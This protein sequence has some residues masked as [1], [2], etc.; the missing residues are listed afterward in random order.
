MYS[1]QISRQ[2]NYGSFWKHAHQ[3]AWEGIYLNMEMLGEGGRWERR[4]TASLGI[5]CLFEYL[6]KVTAVFQKRVFILL[7]EDGGHVAVSFLSK[8]NGHLVRGKQ[9]V[10]T[11]S[12]ASSPA[13]TIQQTA[14]SSKIGLSKCDILAFKYLEVCNEDGRKSLEYVSP[15]LSSSSSSSVRK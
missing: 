14:A 4:V 8:W 13:V 7:R 3:C 5:Q 15:F 6:W 10:L 1:S 9:M 12:W 11:C 2:A